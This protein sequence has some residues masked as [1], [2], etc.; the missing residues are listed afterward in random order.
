[1][2]FGQTEEAVIRQAGQAIARKAEQ[3][4]R[5]GDSILVLAGRGHNGDD[6]CVAGE[7]L[8]GARRKSCA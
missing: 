1:L 7:S 2:G 8:S 5:P 3:L 4:T 6:A